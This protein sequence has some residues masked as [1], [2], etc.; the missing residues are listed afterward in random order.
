MRTVLVSLASAALTSAAL[1]GTAAPPA[2]AANAP[3]IWAWGNDEHGELGD[4]TFAQR[5]SPVYTADVLGG[6]EITQIVA[7]GGVSAALLSNG[8]VWTWGDNFFGALGNG[9][10]GGS[11]ATPGQVPGLT[12]ITQVAIS[13]NGSDLFALGAG[14]VVWGWG[15]NGDGQLGN[16]TT[17]P[18]A[19]P[20]Q[21]PGL[22]GIN[23]IAPGPTYTLALRSNG[24]VLAWGDNADGQLGDGTRTQHRTPVPVPGLN[25]I[26]QV[27]A[28]DPSFAVRFTGIVFAWGSNGNNTGVLGLGA[29]GD[30]AIPTQ[31]PGLAGITH[32]AATGDHVLALANS[33]T[34]YAW[35][36][37][38]AG[39][40]GDGTTTNRS[41]PEPLSLGGVIK[42]A[43]GLGSSAA[44]RSDGTLLTWGDN[45]YGE[46]GVGTCCRVSN[47]VP[48][49]VT[50]LASVSQVAVGDEWML[51]V[52]T[53]AP[54][55]PLAVVPNLGGD[56]RSQASQ[57]LGAVGLVLGTVGS[58]VDNSCNNLGT[59]LSQNPA[60]GSHV[61]LGSAVS[62]TIGVPPKHPCP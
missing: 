23:Q 12:G 22:A 19:L 21:V 8:T 26:V 60:A 44:V 15:L 18:S 10:T 55:P 9:S 1:A 11:S 59:V 4:G 39:E 48:A 27:S 40:L 14:G 13:Y 36:A 34:V 16:G 38:G 57:S 35:G 47:P 17:S 31:I 54:P 42:V 37:N 52:G 33:G 30:V 25:G 50:S 24:T 46:L 62:I 58:V 53:Q 61:S 29:T 6:A 43:A 28:N 3:P 20:M 51:A 7:G 32:L 49:Q 2:V 45:G 5:S 41:T 56:S